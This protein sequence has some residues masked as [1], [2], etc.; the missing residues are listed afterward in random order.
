[1]CKFEDVPVFILI[2]LGGND[3]GRIG[4]KFKNPEYNHKLMIKFN[5]TY[6]I[7]DTLSKLLCKLGMRCISIFP[8]VLFPHQTFRLHIMQ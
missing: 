5:D 1:M 3:I 4:F 8:Y 2:H 6:N 7:N